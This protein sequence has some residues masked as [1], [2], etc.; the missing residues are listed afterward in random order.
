MKSSSFTFAVLIPA[1]NEELCVARCIESCLNQTRKPDQIIVVN[2]GSTD[3]TLAE[4][5]K[6]E[7]KIEIVNIPVAT[8]NKS[9]AQEIGLQ[10][11][12]SDVFIV[13]DG[14]TVLD[15]NF[16]EQIECTFIR[17]PNAAAVAG[18][19]HGSSFN[20]LT[21]IREIDYVIGQDFYKLAQSYLNYIY[22]IAGCAGAFKTKLFTDGLV[23][24]EHDTLTED[25]DFTFKIHRL[26]LPIHFNMKAVCYTQDPHTLHSYVNQMRRWYAGGWQNL[27][28][29]MPIMFKSPSAAW[30]LSMGYLEGLLLPI[31]LLVALLADVHLFVWLIAIYSIMNVLAGLYA[32]VCRKDIR[33]F[34]Y[35]PL[36]TPIKFL[37]AYLYLEQFMKEIVLRRRETVW[38]NP[39]RRTM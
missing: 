34:L 37:Q 21:A 38:F 36:S 39:E 28:K 18:Y 29:H 8:G 16:I 2:D 23:K 33:L 15:K 1:H 31:T 22:V 6:F 3:G 13:T 11:V 19:V 27:R 7:S 17:H 14:D 25:L 26:G 10:Y 20:Y 32:A 4:L 35:S 5:K 9:R 24:I 30:C 12:Q